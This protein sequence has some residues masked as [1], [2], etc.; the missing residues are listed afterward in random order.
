VVAG[1]AGGT[2]QQVD[3][4][5]TLLFQNPDSVKQKGSMVSRQHPDSIEVRRSDLLQRL[6][7]V[8][9][10]VKEALAVLA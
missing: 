8:L 7:V 5:S 1:L 6:Q 3:P 2:K 9:P 4:S 10:V